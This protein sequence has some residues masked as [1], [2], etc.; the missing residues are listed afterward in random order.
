MAMA[1]YRLRLLRCPSINNTQHFRGEADRK[2]LRELYEW[3][4]EYDRALNYVDGV[5]RDASIHAFATGAIAAAK[6]ILASLWPDLGGVRNVL[7]E[8]VDGMVCQH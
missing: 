4:V 5:I 7:S 2:E 3:S 8:Y 1:Y 6:Q